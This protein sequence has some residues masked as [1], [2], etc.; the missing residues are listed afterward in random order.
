MPR[1][2]SASALC[3]KVPVYGFL[4]CNG[5]KRFVEEKHVFARSENFIE[6]TARCQWKIFQQFSNVAAVICRI[7]RRQTPDIS[8]NVISYIR[9][10]QCLFWETGVYE[11]IVCATPVVLIP[12]ILNLCKCFSH[13]LKMGMFVCAFFSFIF[14]CL[15]F[16]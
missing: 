15:P 13:G 4:V 6:F 2:S 1:Y 10:V 7:E 3:A 14:I 16:S 11:C 8:F 12:I 9:Y 5:L